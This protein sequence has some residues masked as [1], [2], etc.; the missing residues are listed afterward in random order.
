MKSERIG[1]DTLPQTVG[2]GTFGQGIREIGIGSGLGPLNNSS[3]GHQSGRT[4]EESGAESM[5][6]QVQ[7]AMAALPTVAVTA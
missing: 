6:V 5:A 7:D 1:T 3:R 2:N 4:G